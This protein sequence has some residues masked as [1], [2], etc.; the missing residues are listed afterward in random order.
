MQTMLFLY[1]ESQKDLGNDWRV[2][3]LQ[4]PVVKIKAG[5]DVS[6]DGTLVHQKT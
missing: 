2:P 1:S 5:M 6:S 3:L 4:Q